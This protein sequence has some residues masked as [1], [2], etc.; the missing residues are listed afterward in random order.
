MGINNVDKS[1]FHSL[2]SGCDKKT[3]LM[4][5]KDEKAN[6]CCILSGL[7]DDGQF[8]KDCLFLPR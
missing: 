2:T 6:S 8:G 3:S 5:D 7:S 4:P 1:R